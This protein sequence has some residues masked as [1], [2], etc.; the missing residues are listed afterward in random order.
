MRDWLGRPTSTMKDLNQLELAF[1]DSSRSGE[2]WDIWEAVFSPVGK[3]G[4]PARIWD[5]RTGT[6][7]HGVA[8]YWKEHYDLTH[9]IQRDWPAIGEKLKGKIHIYV[10]EMDNYFLDNAVYSAEDALKK[11]QHP[12][13][14][15][16]IDYGPRA[17]HC[18][19]GDHTQPNYISRLRYHQMFIPRWAE[20]MKSRAPADADLT[21]WR[22]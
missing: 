15:C 13:C 3:N 9:I 16:E 19:N 12:E 5:K 14:N 1:G 17:E 18:W 21:S 22:Y 7:D 11:L 10:G 20:E 2:Q 8:N 4:Y 6:I